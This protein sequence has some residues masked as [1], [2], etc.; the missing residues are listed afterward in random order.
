MAPLSNATS[1]TTR[2]AGI[3]F[4]AIIN[5]EFL[6]LFSPQLNG[7]TSSFNLLLIIIT[8]SH[9]RCCAGTLAVMNPVRDEFMW[10]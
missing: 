9:R 1:W 5:C 6:V 4:V 3:H 7:N 8:Y 10:A 2:L